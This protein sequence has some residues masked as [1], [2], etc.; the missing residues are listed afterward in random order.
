M[1]EAAHDVLLAEL[2]EL[3]IVNLE[4]CVSGAIQI[5]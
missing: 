1:S 3:M 2:V 5:L 4:L